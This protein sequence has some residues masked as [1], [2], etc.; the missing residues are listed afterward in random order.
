[1]I[2]KYFSTILLERIIHIKF[3]IK[4]SLF[5]L[6]L[7]ILFL[8]NCFYWSWEIYWYTKVGLG[9]IRW[10]THLAVPILIVEVVLMLFLVLKKANLVSLEKLENLLLLVVSISILFFFLELF[11]TATS[12]MKTQSEKEHGI[13]CSVY[14]ANK[15]NR[16]HNWMNFGKTHQLVANEFHY[17]RPTNSEGYSDKEWD[18]D[19]TQKIKILCMGDSFTEGD[20]APQDSCYPVILQKILD[21]EFPDKYE[22][23]NG[24]TCGSDPFFNFK[25]Y[26]EVL[27]KY[28][29][30]FIL[31]TISTHDILSDYAIRGGLERFKKDGTIQYRKA[32]AIEPLYAISYISRIVLNIIGLDLK[33]G[34]KIRSY[35]EMEIDFIQLFSNYNNCAKNNGCKLIVCILPM[36]I[37]IRN[38]RYDLDVKFLNRFHPIN[39]YE[40]YKDSLNINRKTYKEFYW[41]ENAHHNP[42]GYYQMA[43]GINMGIQELLKR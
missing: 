15:K 22:I 25:A 16:Y 24:G 4:F 39:L 30:Q 41:S 32:P 13:Y 20:G 21:H 14:F 1:M 19:T 29:P 27:Y 9:F 2:K 10:H 35:K 23:M 17:I 34:T 37:E 5:K 36:K 31:Q 12:F 6:I 7:G 42:K 38:E 3:S 33:N 8:I 11:F 43:K 26:S 40:I 18:N 28:K